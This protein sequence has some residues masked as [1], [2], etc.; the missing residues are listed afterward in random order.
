[1]LKTIHPKE[2]ILHNE[3]YPLHVRIF[4]CAGLH[5]V[6]SINIFP[7]IVIAPSDHVFL[8][9]YSTPPRWTICQCFAFILEELSAIFNKDKE[10]FSHEYDF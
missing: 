6:Y 2:M 4:L 5:F 10:P 7:Y 1:M 8:I 9:Q 3:R